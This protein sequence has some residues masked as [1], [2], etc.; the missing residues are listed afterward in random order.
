MS[1]YIEHFDDYNGALFHVSPVQPWMTWRYIYDQLN[2]TV[3]CRV[4]TVNIK[5][6]KKGLYAIVRVLDCGPNLLDAMRSG[7]PLTAQSAYNPERQH[8]LE[9]K[10]SEYKVPSKRE[11]VA[12]QAAP[13]KIT[14]E[15]ADQLGRALLNTLHGLSVAPAPRE[16]LIKEQP[17]M[18]ERAGVNVVYEPELLM[19]KPPAKRVRIK[20]VDRVQTTKPSVAIP[21]TENNEGNHPCTNCEMCQWERSERG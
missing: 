18:Q 1:T 15:E 3:M 16:T 7:R 6:G 12:R 5:Q 13:V 21:S 14:R 9:W 10:I 2:A 8:F 20:P 11:T 4:S 19:T 17:Q